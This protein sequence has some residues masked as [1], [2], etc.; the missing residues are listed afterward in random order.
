MMGK[1]NEPPQVID[2][3]LIEEGLPTLSVESNDPHR[4][5]EELYYAVLQNLVPFDEL[6]AQITDEKLRTATLKALLYETHYLEG[7]SG[8][9]ISPIIPGDR[10]LAPVDRDELRIGCLVTNVMEALQKKKLSQQEIADFVQ[11]NLEGQFLYLT[12]PADRR[13]KILEKVYLDI[14]HATKQT[15]LETCDS[16][17]I[18]NSQ[19]ID[20]LTHQLEGRLQLTAKQRA[21]AQRLHQRLAETLHKVP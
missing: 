12:I 11:E 18:L 13:E 1:P 10:G 7:A 21:I 20:F 14:V 6:I 4:I 5:A 9:H 19:I 2:T 16:D 15:V 17:S 3:D 8:K